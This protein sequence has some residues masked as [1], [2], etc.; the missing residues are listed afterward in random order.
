MLVRLSAFRTGRIYAKEILPGGWVD[1]RAVVRSEG[2]M[3][4]KNSMTQSGIE[5]ATLWFVT[6]YLNHCAT[7]VP[8]STYKYW[9]IFFPPGSES[10]RLLSRLKLV[11]QRY[12]AP[13]CISRLQVVQQ[14]YWALPCISRLK[15]GQ[16]R[17]WALSCIQNYS[18]PGLKI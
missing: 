15:L 14:R 7:A 5:P 13:P 1:P 17:Y 10:L 2:F 6:Q 3:S 8:P 16:H 12:C 4:M 9:R 18:F 11:Q